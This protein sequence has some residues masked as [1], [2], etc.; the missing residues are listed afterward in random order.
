MSRTTLRTTVSRDPSLV[1]AVEGA[2]GYPGAS[3]ILDAGDRAWLAAQGLPVP[4]RAPAIP[5]HEAARLARQKR[6]AKKKSRGPKK[7]T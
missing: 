2:A 1:A 5:L 7:G 4:E 6:A 3:A